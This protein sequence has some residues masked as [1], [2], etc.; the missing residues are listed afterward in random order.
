MVDTFQA[1]AVAALA[2]LPGGLYMWA[3]EQ[4]TGRWGVGLADRFLRF[5]GASAVMHASLAPLTYYLYGELVRT[6]RLARGEPLSWWYWMLVLGYVGVPI[7]AGRLVGTGVRRGWRWVRSVGD[8]NPAPR[9][10]DYLFARDKLAGWILLRLKD[11]GWLGGFWAED[12]D[13]GLRSYASG[14]P[15]A[16]ELFIVEQF[17]VVDGRIVVDD[18]GHPVMLG[19]G[20]LVRWDEVAYLEFIEV[21]EAAGQPEAGAGTDAENISG[22]RDP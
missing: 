5:V 4:R 14:Y 12:D 6:G 1:L 9:G 21:A 17:R 8:M 19:R 20:V 11:G 7:L 13:T 18:D 3:R 2:L 22:Q 15:D 16:Q 10:W